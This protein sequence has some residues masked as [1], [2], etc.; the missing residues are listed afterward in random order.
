VT[1]GT[2]NAPPMLAL[3]TTTR[4]WPAGRTP[5]AAAKSRRNES[6]VTCA[7]HGMEGGCVRVCVSS[8][9]G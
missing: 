7:S 4:A 8:K 5:T 3:T 2:A 1:K 6:L 9:G